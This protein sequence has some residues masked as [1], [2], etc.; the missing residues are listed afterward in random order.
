MGGADR[1]PI[2]VCGGD[3]SGRG[4]FCCSALAI[5]QVVFAN[6]SPTVTTICFQPTIVP[7]PSIIVGGM[8]ASARKLPQ[9]YVPCQ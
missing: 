7:I 6:P 5:G 4:D 3:S 1:Q 8:F 2:I 9:R